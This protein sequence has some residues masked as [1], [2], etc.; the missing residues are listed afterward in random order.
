MSLRHEARCEINLARRCTHVTPCARHIDLG[1]KRRARYL[2]FEPLVHGGSCSPQGSPTPHLAYFAGA[3]DF[4]R[5]R[6]ASRAWPPSRLTA[7]GAAGP[8][9]RGDGN[10]RFIRD[11]A[12]AR[13]V[14]AQELDEPTHVVAKAVRLRIKLAWGWSA[15]W[16]LRRSTRSRPAR[17][18]RST[19]ATPFLHAERQAG[20][21]DRGAPTRRA[22]PEPRR[23][24]RVTGLPCPRASCR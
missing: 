11:G 13:P 17:R 14:F 20:F 8:I 21:Y 7:V 12:D 6:P 24:N 9:S 3:H 10:Y 4:L 2:R 18:N 19:G 15:F 23:G 16:A 5:R 22:T 1:S